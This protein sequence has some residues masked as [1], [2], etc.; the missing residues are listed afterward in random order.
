MRS[1]HRFWESFL[2]KCVTVVAC[3]CL[4]SR[5]AQLS[6]LLNAPQARDQL[7]GFNTI[8]LAQFQVFRL[9]TGHLTQPPGF[10]STKR[11][12]ARRGRSFHSPGPNPGFRL[13]KGAAR[14]SRILLTRLDNGGLDKKRLSLAS[15][16]RNP[17]FRLEK[18]GLDQK[19]LNLAIFSV[20]WPK[21][22]FSARQAWT[23]RG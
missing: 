1:C 4:A 20:I 8:H 23:R 17:G 3:G 10:G 22:R 9:D 14:R 5:N 11:V 19:R 7:L 6:S 21:P 16:G 12:R 18:G 15:S 2:T 13:H